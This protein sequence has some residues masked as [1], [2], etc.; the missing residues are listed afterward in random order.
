[1]LLKNDLQFNRISEV[2]VIDFKK[3]NYCKIFYFFLFSFIK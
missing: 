3:N 2:S 1:M